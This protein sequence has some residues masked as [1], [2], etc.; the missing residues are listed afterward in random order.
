MLLKNQQFH[1]IGDCS[2]RVPEFVTQH[3]QELVLAVVLVCQRRCL[4]LRP[5]FQTASFGDVPNVAL[6]DF[7][8]FL[9]VGINVVILTSCRD[10]N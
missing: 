3:R 7:V 10:E 6:N 5:F 9:P 1:S 8:V 2:Q 4:F